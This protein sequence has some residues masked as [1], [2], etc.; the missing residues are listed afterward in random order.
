M[1]M[2]SDSYLLQT[3]CSTIFHMMTYSK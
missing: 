1:K 2:N 3:D